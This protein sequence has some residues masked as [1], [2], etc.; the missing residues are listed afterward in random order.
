MQSFLSDDASIVL[1]SFG[2]FFTSWWWLFVG[3]IIGCLA[4]KEEKCCEE[5]I[6]VIM[7]VH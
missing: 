5:G 4:E 2:G 3:C 6:F 1:W 7:S